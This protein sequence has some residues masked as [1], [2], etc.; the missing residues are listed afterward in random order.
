MARANAVTG[1]DG[2]KL[3]FGLDLG[4][5]PAGKLG[6][7]L[8]QKVYDT[9]VKA[10]AHSPLFHLLG[11]PRYDF[12]ARYLVDNKGLR[13]NPMCKHSYGESITMIITG[14]VEYRCN[15]R[16]HKIYERPVK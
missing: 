4:N 1:G 12:L 5:L 15:R 2:R 10:A 7:G 11:L 8:E 6:S 9:E 14:G 16:N 3:A 13:H